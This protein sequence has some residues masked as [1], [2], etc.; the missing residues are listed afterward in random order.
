MARNKL[1]ARELEN[2]QDRNARNWNRMVQADEDEY[3]AVQA[4]AEERRSGFQLVD[5]AGDG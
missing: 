4:E 2:I 1:T 5:G 3:R